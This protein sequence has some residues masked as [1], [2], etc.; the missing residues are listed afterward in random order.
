MDITRFAVMTLLE[1]LGELCRRLGH[2]DL[3]EKCSECVEEVNT[4][5][6]LKKAEG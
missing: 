1:V 3:C 6:E 5:D 2:A 4:H